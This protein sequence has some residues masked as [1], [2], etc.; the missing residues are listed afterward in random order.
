MDFTK[1]IR[2]LDL[3]GLIAKFNNKRILTPKLTITTRLKLY[4]ASIA[5][6]KPVSAV[7]ATA[8]ETYLLRNE[9]KHQSEIEVIAT[10]RGCDVEDVITDE[11]GI[12]LSKSQKSDT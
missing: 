8:I 5:T 2:E 1:I 12:R 10:I 4:R 7:I 9:E 3:K 6:N 11:I